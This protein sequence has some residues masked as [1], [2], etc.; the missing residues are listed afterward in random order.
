MRVTVEDTSANDRSNKE[1]AFKNDAPFKSCIS[2]INIIFIENAENLDIVMPMYNLLEY[3]K[4]YSMAS[5]SLWNYYRNE[6]NDDANKNNA[7]GYYR[8]NNNKATTTRSFK[9]KTEIKGSTPGDNNILNIEVAA[10][11]EINDFNALIDNK[12]LFAQPVKNKQKAY[13]KIVEILRN[14]N[15]PTGNLLDYSCHQ[16]HHK[17]I[18]IDLLRQTN[19]TIP[20]KKYF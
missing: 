5:G 7:A 8:I 10:P 20:Q 6:V 13:E 4:N 2:K 12:P 19:T 16:N 11:A 9:F 1:L 14:N 15:Y 3:S 18:V 17:M